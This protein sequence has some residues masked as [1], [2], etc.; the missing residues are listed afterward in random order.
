[1]KVGSVNS[2]DVGNALARAWNDGQ[3]GTW[4]AVDGR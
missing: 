1:M 2:I 3:I 4:L